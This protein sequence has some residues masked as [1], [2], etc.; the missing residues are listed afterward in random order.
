MNAGPVLVTWQSTAV[1]MEGLARTLYGMLGRPVV[2]QTGLTGRYDVELQYIRD[3]PPGIGPTAPTPPE[4]PA[5]VDAI[6]EQLGLQ[7]KAER[8]P[9]TVLIVESIQRPSVDEN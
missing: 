5:L 7:L 3:M 4:G 2:D 1:T 9:T 8:V 6:K